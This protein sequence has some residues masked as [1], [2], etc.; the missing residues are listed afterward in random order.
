M[1]LTLIGHDDRYAVEQLQMALFPDNLD[2]EATSTLH[3]GETWLTATARITIG[4]KTVSAVRRLKAS[5][6]TVRLR[7]R[8]LQQSCCPAFPPGALWQESAPP[9]SPP[10][11]C[12]K[13]AP[14]SP[15]TS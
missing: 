12:W 2:G 3:R 8:C 1:K 11:T 7:R 13:A 15:R 9:R 10:S 6:E 5:E 14:Q 4:D